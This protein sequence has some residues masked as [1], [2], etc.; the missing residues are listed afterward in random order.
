MGDKLLVELPMASVVGFIAELVEPGLVAVR[1]G[2][3]ADTTP[4]R[5]LVSCVI[6]LPVDA[7]YGAVP[8]VVKVYD[9]AKEGALEALESVS[10]KPEPSRSN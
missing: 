6:A 9:A 4:G 2:Q 1:R 8:Q 10:G 7:E 5:I 3:A